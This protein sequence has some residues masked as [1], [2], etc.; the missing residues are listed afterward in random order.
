MCEVHQIMELIKKRRII[1]SK[2]DLWNKIDPGLLVVGGLKQESKLSF[3]QDDDGVPNRVCQRYT[4]KEQLLEEAHWSPFI[5]HPSK[6]RVKGTLRGPTGGELSGGTL[7]T[8]WL[9]VW[10]FSRWRWVPTTNKTVTEDTYLGI[11]VGACH[12]I[13]CY[14]VLE[15]T[16][17]PKLHLSDSRW[18]DQVDSSPTHLLTG[19]FFR[20]S[21]FERFWG[22]MVYLSILL[23]MTHCMV[24]HSC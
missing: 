7:C 16:E 5:V 10:W 8:L 6:T 19:L 1:H 24:Y 21:C 12:N 4:I 13:F 14:E 9:D 23:G 22:C 11:E 2:V 15:F 20:L 3:T 17:G 18:F